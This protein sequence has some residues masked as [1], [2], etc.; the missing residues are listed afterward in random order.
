M[1][2]RR[3]ESRRPQAPVAQARELARVGARLERA[4]KE[5]LHRRGADLAKVW[6]VFSAV[7]H[8]AVLARGYAL[9][10]SEGRKPLTTAEATRKAASFTIQFSDGELPANSGRPARKARAKAEERQDSLF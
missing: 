2:A 10:W 1:L 9:V 4:F 5:A 3:F 6:Q 8:H 7:N